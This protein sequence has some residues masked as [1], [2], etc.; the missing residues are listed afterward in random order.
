MKEEQVE[1]IRNGVH[2][3]RLPPSV[4]IAPSVN[5]THDGDGCLT[6]AAMQEK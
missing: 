3:H 4:N 2:H 1:L 5:T 6:Q